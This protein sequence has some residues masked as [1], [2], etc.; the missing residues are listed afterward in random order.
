MGCGIYLA[1]TAAEFTECS[2]LP[3]R[4]A[5]MACH[6]SPYGQGLS[7][8]PSSLP[9][10]SILILNDRVSIREHDPDLI[11]RQLR[12]AALSL[13]AGCVLL[14]FEHPNEPRIP[15]LIS[16]I[17]ESIPC[18][19]VVSQHYAK[20]QNVGVFLSPCPPAIPL[21]TYLAPW[22]GREIWL[23]AAVQ[24]Q[25]ITVTKDGSTFSQPSRQDRG[26]FPH[27]DSRLCCRYRI[28][29]DNDTARFILHRGKAELNDLGKEAQSLGLKAM[30]GLYQELA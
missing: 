3:E 26:P 1:M 30:V 22:K 7:N 27:Q 6:F 23:D 15:P 5:W 2:S 16:K 24:T 11:A 28:E 17:K 4:M 19:L 18:P 20:E 8:I 13:K 25:I 10:G 12:N 29:T 14:D 21:K 9:P